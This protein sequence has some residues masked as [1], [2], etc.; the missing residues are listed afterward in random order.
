VLNEARRQRIGYLAQNGLRIAIVPLSP[1]PKRQ[2]GFALVAEPLNVIAEGLRRLR[3][4]FFAGVPVIL[5]LA[6]LGGYFLARKSL[7]PIALMSEQTR[8]ITA[9]KLSLRSTGHDHQRIAGASGCGLPGA[10]TFHRRCL[11]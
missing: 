3:R 11:P 2:L 7:S 10:E 4:D 6:S 5:L 8:R 1:D 9:E